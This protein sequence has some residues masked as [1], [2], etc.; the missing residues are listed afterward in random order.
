MFAYIIHVAILLLQDLFFGFGLLLQ[1]STGDATG[2]VEGT[3][4]GT[5]GEEPRVAARVAR[6]GRGG[7]G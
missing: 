2:V 5:R 6:V 1:N 3:T 7:S 4:T